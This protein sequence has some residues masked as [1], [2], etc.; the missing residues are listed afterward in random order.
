MVAV[1]PN[2]LLMTTVTVKKQKKTPRETAKVPKRLE[3]VT[4]LAPNMLKTRELKAQKERRCLTS[5]ILTKK[6]KR[7]EAKASFLRQR[8]DTQLPRA[9]CP[10]KRASSPPKLLAQLNRMLSAKYSL[11]LG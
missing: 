7:S 4:I 8:A 3:L 6:R 1:A 2:R 11:A 9:N 5:T 10:H